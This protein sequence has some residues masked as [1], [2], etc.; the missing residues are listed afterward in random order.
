MKE[1]LQNLYQSHKTSFEFSGA[2]LII[3]GLFLNIPSPQS[4]VGSTSLHY[5]NFF[6]LFLACIIV[7]Y[8]IYAITRELLDYILDDAD[9]NDFDS[10][11]H[12][13]QKQIDFLVK[14]VLMATFLILIAVLILVNLFIFIF[15]VY[16]IE[17]LFIIL[18]VISYLIAYKSSK[19]IDKMAAL[20]N[21]AIYLY[22]FWMCLLVFFVP[23]TLIVMLYFGLHNDVIGV[24]VVALETLSN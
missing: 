12:G 21:F 15:D 3:T 8:L 24:F 2:M 9:R 13:L 6:L 18:V 7:G 11:L 22:V 10:T 4:I 23:I 17:F 16:T 1:V 14:K 5:V 19:L 20:G